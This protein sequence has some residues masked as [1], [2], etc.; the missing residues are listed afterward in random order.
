MD[1][2]VHV[3]FFCDCAVVCLY[4]DFVLFNLCRCVE[5]ADLQ[6]QHFLMARAQFADQWSLYSYAACLTNS[7]TGQRSRGPVKHD[8][9]LQLGVMTL[10]TQLDLWLNQSSPELVVVILRTRPMNQP[11]SSRV[12]ALEKANKRFTSLL[13]SF[14][15]LLLLHIT[16]KVSPQLSSSWW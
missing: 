4:A 6:F 7:T 5:L 1:V 8:H 12:L 2:C 3:C 13:R 11:N 9:V 14:S 10:W 16:L 15:P